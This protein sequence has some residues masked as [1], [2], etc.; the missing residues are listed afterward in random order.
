MRRGLISVAIFAAFVVILTLSRHVIDPS[1]STT[2]TGVPL[3]TTT[4]APAT[5][6][7]TT[8]VNAASCPASDFTGVFNQGEGAAGT[9]YASVTLTKNTGTA[10]ALMGWPILTLQDKT[11]A[12]LPVSLVDESGAGAVHFTAAKANGPPSQL[13]LVN[14]SSTSFSLAYSDVATAKTV[15][16]DAVTISVQFVVNGPTVALTPAYP[17]QPCDNGKIWL[18]PF[19]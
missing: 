10:C 11:G 12:V 6:T 19:Y 4:A 15:C 5:T 2:T 13:S 1:S 17:V 8:V 9:I 16:D 7:S 14:G 3:T 18:S